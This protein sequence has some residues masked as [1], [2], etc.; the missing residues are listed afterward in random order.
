[1]KSIIAL[2]LCAAAVARAQTPDAVP[3]DA[4]IPGSPPDHVAVAVTEPVVADVAAPTPWWKNFQ[5]FGYAKVGVF[6]TLPTRDEQIPGGNGGF[7]M[8][9]LRLGTVFQPI[10]NLE[11]VASIEGAAP[12][13]RSE[14]PTSGSRVVQLRDAYAEYAV[15]SGFLVRAGQFKAPFWAESLLAD[16]QLPFTS[17][18]VITEGYTA[19]EFAGQREGLSLDR[20]VGVQL[21]SR[22]LGNKNVGFKYAL[23]VVNG[24]G[25]NQLLNDNNSVAPVGRLEVELFNHVTLGANGYYNSRAEGVRPNRLIS[26]QIGYA[27]DIVAHA[28]GFSIL[29]GYIGRSTSS[30]ST[31]LSADTSSGI[32]GQLHYL[33]ERSGIAG[34]VRLALFDPSKADPNDN[35]TEISVMLSWQLSAAP[36]RI[37]VQYTHRDESAGVSVPNDAVD[38]MLQATW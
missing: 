2:V 20:Q 16:S 17:R 19:P 34:G 21:S 36:L 33:H 38:A 37:L 10:K 18:S 32:L 28:L 12:V 3:P 8:V 35:V 24:N 23:A 9:S 31:A 4:G 26:N 15:C 22:R 6:Y 27:G 13:A 11:V 29:V 5:P 25:A 7:R 1:L 30:P 14:D